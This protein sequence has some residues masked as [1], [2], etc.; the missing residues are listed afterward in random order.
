MLKAKMESA[1]RRAG[2]VG[3][4]RVSGGVKA[5][6]GGMTWCRAAGQGASRVAHRLA[7]SARPHRWLPPIAWAMAW[8]ATAVMSLMSVLAGAGLAGEI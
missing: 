7:R 5:E 4:A 3:G 6:S 8:G 1:G 2:K